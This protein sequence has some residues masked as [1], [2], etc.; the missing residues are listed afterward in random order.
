MNVFVFLLFPTFLFKT[1]YIFSQNYVL[2]DIPSLNGT[3]KSYCVAQ[4][5]LLLLHY[6]ILIN[7]YLLH[8]F[9]LYILQFHFFYAHPDLQIKMF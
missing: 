2:K 8:V 5:R 1:F 3:F 9:L 6:C 4:L 7:V